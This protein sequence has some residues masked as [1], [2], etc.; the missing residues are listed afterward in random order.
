MSRKGSTFRKH[1]EPTTGLK[2]GGCVPA[3]LGHSPPQLPPLPPIQFTPAWGLEDSGADR[4]PSS[5]GQ[6]GRVGGPAWPH[7][8]HPA[9]P[10]LLTK[11]SRALLSHA[12]A[13]TCQAHV[14]RPPQPQPGSKGTSSEKPS[15]TP[16]ELPLSEGAH[17]C[18]LPHTGV[19]GCTASPATKDTSSAIAATPRDQSCL[20]AWHKVGGSQCVTGECADQ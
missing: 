12:P 3:R 13:W 9:Y 15:M 11:A 7:Q 5:P 8:R 10:R 4:Q 6:R 2:S 1:Q 14:P 18:V 20:G 16:F 19:C 17:P